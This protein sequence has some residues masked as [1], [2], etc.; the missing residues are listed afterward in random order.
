[1][2]IITNYLDANYMNEQNIPLWNVSTL[3]GHRTNNDLEGIHYRLNKN[4]PKRPHTSF[5]QFVNG[6]RK[7]QRMEDRIVHQLNQGLNFK[8]RERF[9]RAREDNIT[10]LKN[11][12]AAN[13]I[14]KIQFLTEISQLYF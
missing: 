6:I 7:E 8:Y 14:T 12:Y 10:L 3:A 1:M 9:Y 13:N 5:W 2:D 11:N 4:L